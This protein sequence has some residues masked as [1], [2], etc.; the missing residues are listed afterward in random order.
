VSESDDP[1]FLK[2]P[3]I[4]LA[5]KD[6]Y[7]TATPPRRAAPPPEP[8]PAPAA[9]VEQRVP[10]E[11][12]KEQLFRLKLAAAREADLREARGIAWAALA[13][14]VI[15]SALLIFEY[16]TPGTI[17]IN[18][19]IP[20]VVIIIPCVLIASGYLVHHVLRRLQGRSP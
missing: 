19:R 13:L 1:A 6:P 3:P 14:V 16:V 10:D 12:P 15:G 9:P 11:D 4:P 20:A 17:M 5:G 2:A 7:R 8:E 18:R